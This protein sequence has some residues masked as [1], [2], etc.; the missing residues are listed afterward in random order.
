MLASILIILLSFALLVYWVRYASLLLLNGA[1]A[2]E[3]RSY[4]LFHFPGVKAQLRDGK[5]DE[6]LQQALD[7]DYAALTYLMDRVPMG[8]E[9]RL[10]VWDYR[11]MRCWY[12]ISGTAFP[13]QSRKALE[14]M[15]DV[16]AALASK[17]KDA[18][19]GSH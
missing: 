12:A 5:D 14:E 16:V 13:V 3:A 7:R 11:L 10:L 9:A 6:K 17:L 2:D 19:A 15:T 18:T 1:K 4:P 8:A